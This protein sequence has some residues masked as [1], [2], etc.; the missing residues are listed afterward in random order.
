L[1]KRDFSIFLYRIQL[2]YR[3]KVKNLSGFKNPTGLKCL[4]IKWMP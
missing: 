3:S 1:T 2:C 4:F